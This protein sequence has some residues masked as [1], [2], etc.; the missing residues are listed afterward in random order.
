MIMMMIIIII[1]DDEC[2]RATREK[3]SAG[4]KEGRKEEK[5]VWPFALYHLEY[6]DGRPFYSLGLL[7]EVGE[8]EEDE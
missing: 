1:T 4:R 7:S 5:R 2:V 3:A 6:V 8:E